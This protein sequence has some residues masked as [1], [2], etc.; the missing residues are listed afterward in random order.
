MTTRMC[1]ICGILAPGIS[2]NPFQETP[3]DIFVEQSISYEQSYQGCYIPIN[4]EREITRGRMRKTE[5]ETIY[6]NIEK[7]TDENEIITISEKAM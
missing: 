1:S 3:D 6:I 4:I 7:G 2:G 5:K